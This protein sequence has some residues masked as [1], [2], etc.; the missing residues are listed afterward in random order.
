MSKPY[1]HGALR[2][3]LLAAAERLLERG[4]VA[5]VT[6]RAV[7]REAG[8]SHGAPA[9]HF[10][11]FA[12]LLS[13]VATRGFGR[14]A[15]E[16]AAADAPQEDAR[17]RGLGQSYVRFARRNPHL[18]VLMFRSDQL[19]DR[20]PALSAARQAAF[21]LLAGADPDEHA[22]L[23]ATARWA[24]AHGL[25]LLAIDG[26]LDAVAAGTGRDQAA[27]VAAVLAAAPEARGPR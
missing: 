17:L 19:D 24:L 23:R 11:D 5:A 14:L 6:L 16:M 25:A 9:H 8:V 26:R 2:E 12:D 21:V 7:A 15:A 1:H 10:R 22:I 13:A 4:G 3:A 20:D 27:L 18:F